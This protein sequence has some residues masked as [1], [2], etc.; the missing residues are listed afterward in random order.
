MLSKKKQY[1]LICG[2]GLMCGGLMCGEMRYFCKLGC[3]NGFV[4]HW[5]KFMIVKL[6]IFCASLSS[7][8]FLG[9]KP[10]YFPD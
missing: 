1:G 3:R 7:R 4:A 10:S 5:R 8:K 9:V 2:E 6:Q